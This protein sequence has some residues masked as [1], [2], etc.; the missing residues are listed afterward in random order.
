LSRKKKKRAPAAASR[1]RETTY[2]D[3]RKKKKAGIGDVVTRK[4]GK[5]PEHMRQRQKVVYV[6]ATPAERKE[7]GGV[8][9]PDLRKKKVADASSDK[10]WK[11]P[12]SD[13]LDRG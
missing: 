4:E 13:P 5:E 1:R 9:L 11:R 10:G 6:R 3:R 8:V 7:K 2:L 12:P